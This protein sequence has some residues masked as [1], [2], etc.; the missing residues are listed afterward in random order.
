LETAVEAHNSAGKTVVQRS[1]RKGGQRGE[2]PSSVCF[3]RR[4]EVQRGGGGGQQWCLVSFKAG[5]DGFLLKQRK[6]GAWTGAA[7]EWK[8]G[9]GSG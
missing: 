8:G 1:A 2:V 6:T 7:K 9:R 4:G 5:H 3:I